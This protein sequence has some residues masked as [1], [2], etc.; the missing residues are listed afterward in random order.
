MEGADIH[1]GLDCSGDCRIVDLLELLTHGHSLLVGHGF[2][3]LRGEGFADALLAP[4]L[5]FEKHT[6]L[7]DRPDSRALPWRTLPCLWLC[8][9]H[10]TPPTHSW[11]IRGD[12]F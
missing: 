10:V 7:A 2:P 8:C 12:G 9:C 11:N 1:H 4:R 3:P 6:Q 5:D